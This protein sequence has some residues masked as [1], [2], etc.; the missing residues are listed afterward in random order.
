MRG[1][2][3]RENKLLPE[4]WELRGERRATGGKKDLLSLETPVNWLPF[5]F[6]PLLFNCHGFLMFKLKLFR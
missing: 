2:K 5:I 6:N 4:C 1:N 3:G